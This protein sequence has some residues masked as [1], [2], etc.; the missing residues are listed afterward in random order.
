MKCVTV[1]YEAVQPV[2]KMSYSI[3]TTYNFSDQFSF[4]LFI[5]LL[6]IIRKRLLFVVLG[7]HKVD[8]KY[9]LKKHLYLLVNNK[10]SN[11]SGFRKVG[12]VYHTNRYH[13][14]SQVFSTL[15]LIRVIWYT[16]GSVRHL[17]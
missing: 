11:K 5:Y 2:Y 17:Q 7:S 10:S 14:Q 16:A 9:V 8:L 6:R 4:R 13:C 15:S 12:Y 3:T 1:I